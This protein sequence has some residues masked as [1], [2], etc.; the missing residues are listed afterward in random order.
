MGCAKPESDRLGP[1]LPEPA[2]ISK[3]SGVTVGAHLQQVDQTESYYG[4]VSLCCKYNSI[5]NY[6]YYARSFITYCGNA[7]HSP[8]PAG[9]TQTPSGLALKPT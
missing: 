7:P 4:F 6:Q 1:G 9:L 8:V 2:F 5:K 3:Y